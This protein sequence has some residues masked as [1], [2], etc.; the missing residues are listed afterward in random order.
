ME[1]SVDLHSS[2]SKTCANPEQS[3]N[4][5]E[6]TILCLCWSKKTVDLLW[7]Q[8]NVLSEP[9]YIDQITRPAKDAI[10]NEGIEAGLHCERQALPVG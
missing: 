8:I 9:Y 7:A 2:Q 4:H 6:N 5:A 10:S 3:R 1:A